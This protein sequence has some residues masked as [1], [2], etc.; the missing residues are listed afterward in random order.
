MD[1]KEDLLAQKKSGA[2]LG[3][4]PLDFCKAIYRESSQRIDDLHDINVE[5]HEFYEGID[6]VLD[7]RRSNKLVERSAIFVHQL[8]P[9]I[10]TRI[11][12][13]VAALEMDEFPIDV[14]TA[15]DNVS[16][17]TYEQ[18]D[19]IRRN[20]NRQLRDCGYLTDKFEEQA[21]A[22][23]IY[24]TP[25]AVKIG[26]EEYTSR[27]AVVEAPPEID[28]A[29]AIVEQKEMR[30]RV[31]F[32]Y[33]SKGRPYVD[34]LRPEEF[35]YQPNV[36]RFEESAYVG[37]RMRKHEWEIMAMV[38]E[39]G[40][41]AKKAERYFDE[42]ESSDETPSH[43]PVHEEVEEDR[44]T[45]FD[46]DDNGRHLLVEWY[47]VDYKDD[48]SEIIRHIVV[49]G[50]KEVLHDKPSKYKGLRFPFVVVTANRQL[51]NI[52]NLSSVDKGKSMQRVYNE[53]F[54]SFIDGMTYRIFPPFLA[55]RGLTFDGEPVYG[56]GR[57]WWLDD[58]SPDSFRPAVENPGQMPDLPAL[59]E[60][61]SAKLRD[62]L[63]AQD[64]QQGFQA[65]QY[66]KA[67]STKLRAMGAS[68]RATP[69]RKKYG[70]AIVA[71]AE[72][73][74]SLNQQFDSE[75]YAWVV[76]MVIDVPS[77]TN[78]SDPDSEK[79]DALLLYSQMA[80]DPLFQSPNGMRKRRN[81]WEDVVRKFK[82]T[83]VARFVLTEDEL[84]SDIEIQTKM[85]TNMMD[86]Q[87]IQQ[88]MQM[89]GM[90]GQP[91]SAQGAT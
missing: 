12:D 73:F 4:D 21:R 53:S 49:L 71:V 20:L 29:M 61:V 77:L 78:V 18:V 38:K 88:Q 85:Q 30:P 62:T 64:I 82:K 65:R 27:K 74:V 84:N 25:S 32:E 7:E 69:T 47:L 8:T 54:N 70:L 60:A 50:N 59:M 83:D 2:V 72:A 45:G 89:A 76:D 14:R 46:I 16:R 55:R 51:G 33:E 58:P 86:Q 13:M 22:A 79:E 19:W 56:P 80:Q 24:R 9:A 34:W 91:A 87:Q 40:W 36:S 67:T 10:D 31:R 6:K 75:G 35:L 23:E 90:R 68:R 43:E 81:A 52:E 66:E 28:P 5:N 42:C 63:N 37:H 41:D 26:W 17:E 15:Q 44:G 57:I 11:G 1:E 39:F 48:G 3:K